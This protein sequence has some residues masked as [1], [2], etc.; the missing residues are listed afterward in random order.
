MLRS[1]G[2]QDGA[3]CFF[4]QF[5]GIITEVAAADIVP[6]SAKF[7][8]TASENSQ[9][10]LQAVVEFQNQRSRQSTNDLFEC[11]IGELYA[12]GRHGRPNSLSILLLFRQA[13]R[14]RLIIDVA[15]GRLT[16]LM[17]LQR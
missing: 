13:L 12:T 1:K 17:S 3:G 8:I 7:T 10:G 9:S 16:D 15:G 6:F 5:N 14:H 2:P 11:R 4:R